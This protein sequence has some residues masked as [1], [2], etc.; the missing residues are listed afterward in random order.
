[1]DS[2]GF[3]TTVAELRPRRERRITEIDF[4]RIG[5]ASSPDEAL[6]TASEKYAHQV[7]IYSLI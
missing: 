7:T 2:A 4:S 5:D 3:S 6:R 1:M